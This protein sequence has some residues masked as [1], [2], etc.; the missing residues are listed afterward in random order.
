VLGREVVVAARRVMQ[1]GARVRAL[2]RARDRM[3]AD[4]VVVAMGFGRDVRAL[5]GVGYRDTGCEP[6]SSTSS[7]VTFGDCSAPA[8]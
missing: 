5:C 4:M 1:R 3:S 8:G 6:T 7:E 2:C